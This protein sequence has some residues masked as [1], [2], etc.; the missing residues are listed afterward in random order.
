[1]VP[2]KFGQTKAPFSPLEPRL[3][4][5]GFTVAA[6]TNNFAEAR[7]GILGCPDFRACEAKESPRCHL[8]GFSHGFSAQDVGVAS[9]PR[10][11]D[12]SLGSDRFDVD[13]TRFWEFNLDTRQQIHPKITWHRSNIDG[14]TIHRK[15]PTHGKMASVGPKG[16]YYQSD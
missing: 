14:T 13:E 5:S 8:N 10:C 12:R 16:A 6:L 2:F 3:R 4:Q 9:Q 7:A 1:M 15:G 11:F